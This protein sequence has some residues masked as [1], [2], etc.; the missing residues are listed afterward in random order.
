[1]ARLRERRKIVFGLTGGLILFI[2]GISLTFQHS[3]FGRTYA[4]YGG[5]FVIMSMIWGWM[6]DKKRP[7]RFEIIGGVIVLIGT[8]IIFYSPR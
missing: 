3:N 5:I 1:M 6:I 4:A 7:D 2:Y 8:L